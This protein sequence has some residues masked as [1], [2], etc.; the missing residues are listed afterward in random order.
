MDKKDFK[1]LLFSFYNDEAF[2]IRQLQAILHAHGYNVKTVFVKGKIQ[3]SFTGEINKLALY[4]S[5]LTS[6]SK[7][8]G[9]KDRIVNLITDYRQNKDINPVS[10]LLE[11]VSL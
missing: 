8:C 11:T 10:R 3:D 1:I 9:Q 7:L 4:I 6:H 2:G 5:Y